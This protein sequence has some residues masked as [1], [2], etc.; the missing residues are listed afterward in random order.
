MPEKRDEA[1][2]KR[3]AELPVVIALAVAF[4]GLLAMLIVDHGP[5]SRPKVQSAEVANYS[6]TG[7]AARAAGAKVTPTAPKP[8]IEPEMP[9]PKPV[10]PSDV[11]APRS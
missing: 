3:D 2:S 7:D 11:P 9:G 5:W 10:Q 8:E 1:R 4:F 6:T